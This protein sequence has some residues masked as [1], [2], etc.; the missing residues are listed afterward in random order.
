MR[1]VLAFKHDYLVEDGNTSSFKSGLYEEDGRI[2]VVVGKDVINPKGAVIIKGDISTF[3]VKSSLKEAIIEFISG[4]Q[5]MIPSILGAEKLKGG[6]NTAR[7]ILFFK[8]SFDCY[9]LRMGLYEAGWKIVGIVTK[10]MVNSDGEIT[11]KDDEPHVHEFA[12]LKTGIVEFIEC[13]SENM[14]HT[15]IAEGLMHVSSLQQ[16]QVN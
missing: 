13:V 4:I 8:H 9:S 10:D 3:E 15:L 6:G 12:D 7:Q 16:R 2:I 11:Q 14:E 5:L 1:Q